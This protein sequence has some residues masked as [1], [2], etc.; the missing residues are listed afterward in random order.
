MASKVQDHFLR[1]FMYYY[2]AYNLNI[3]SEM[4]FP[5][6]SQGSGGKDVSIIFR[7]IKLDEYSQECEF[8][9]AFKVKFLNNDLY[10]FSDEIN[11]CKI[12]EGNKIFINPE[13]GFDDSYLRIIILGP[14]LTL[15]L[16]QR[17]NLILHSSA[18]NINGSVVA[19][20]GTNGMGKS[21][22]LFALNKRGYP[23]ITDDILS[24]S[25]NEYSVPLVNPSY[26]RLKLREDVMNFMYENLDSTPKTHLY[27]EKY[28]YV[29]DN[30]SSK[31][32][33]LSKIYLVEKADANGLDSVSPTESLM[34]LIKS[35]YCYEIFRE[36][37]IVENLI[38]CANLVERV[39]I[40][41]L[42]INH[43]LK[44]LQDLVQIIESDN[45]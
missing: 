31:P 9:A 39:S 7:K 37:E 2:K 21:T 10:L 26:P 28:S 38:Q 35:S 1:F 20:L 43:S 29:T 19:F 41:R 8:S 25:F 22:T 13:T 5:E 3:Q 4:S 45:K 33:L 34:Q 40:K 36:N 12:S 32:I 44:K 11:V 23:L 15:L 42:K 17:K 18:V 30:F 27:S 6:L 14:A 24:V 16:H